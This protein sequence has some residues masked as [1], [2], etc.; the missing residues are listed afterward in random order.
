MKKFALLLFALLP[1]AAISQTIGFHENFELPS[2]ADS[3]TSSGAPN[4]WAITTKLSHGG[5]RSDSCRVSTGDTSYL[6]CAPFS[7]IG[8]S[9]VILRFSHICKAEI[10]DAGEI[11][12]SA[13]GGAWTKLTSIQYINPGNSQFVNSGNKFN[14]NTYPL[15]WAPANQTAIPTNTWWKNEQFDIS[16]LAG[17]SNNVRVRFVL[18]DGNNNGNNYNYGW[19]IDDISV[20]MSFSELNPPTITYINPL[21]LNIVYNIGPFNIPAIVSD[22]SGISVA[23]MFYKVNNGP[24]DSVTMTTI[25]S[26]TMQ[27]TIPA[28]LEGDSVHYYIVAYDASPA[29]NSARNPVSGYRSFL[30]TKGVSLPF[31]DNFDSPTTLFYDT[32]FTAGTQWQLGTPSYGT[33]A[34]AHSSPNAWDINLSTAYTDNAEAYLYSPIFDFSTVVNATMSFWI[35]YNTESYCDGMRIDYTIDG[36][37]WL[38]LGSV[39]DTN[40]T[41]WYDLSSISPS[42]KPA[43]SG[44]SSGWKK[45]TYLLS[46][47]NNVVGPV[48]FRFVF[49]SDGSST[50]DGFSLDDF[51]LVPPLDIDAIMLSS[52]TPDFSSCVAAGSYNPVIDF[53]NSGQLNIAPPFNLAYQLDGSAP[54][55]QAY[56]DTLHSGEADT[57][58]FTTPLVLPTGNHILKI[59]VAVPGDEFLAN[60]TLTFNF[61]SHGALALPYFNWL[62][63]AATLN[64]FCI[65]TGAYGRV[66]FNTIAASTGT[67]GVI[68]DANSSMGWETDIDT[69][70]TDTLYVWDPVVNPGQYAAMTLTVNSATYSHIVMKFDAKQIL[71]FDN[72]YTNFRVTVNGTQVTPHMSPNGASTQYITHEIDLTPFLPAPTLTIVFE[73]KTLATYDYGSPNGTATYIDNIQIYEPPAQEAAAFALPS[74]SSG[75]G[76]GVETVSIK[77]RNSGSDT[78]NGNLAAVYKVNGGAPITPETIITEILP[79]DTLLYTFTTTI[80]MSVTNIDS[81][82]NITAWVQLLSDPFAFNDTVYKTVESMFV[83]ANPVTTAVLVIPYATDTVL[84]ATSAGNLYW[85]DNPTTT[86]YLVMDSVFQTP[87]L[88]DTTTFYVEARNGAAGNDFY[89]GTGT[90]QNGTTGFPSPYGQYYNGTREQLLIPASELTAAG[91]GPGPIDGLAFDVVTPAGDPL[92]NLTL[93]LGTTNVTALSGWVSSG[94]QQVFTVASYT[95][96]T[97]WNQH[98]FSTPFVWD[99]VS[100]LVVESCFD[101]YPN[102][103]SSNAV[104]NQTTTTYAST[105]DYHSDNGGV[106]TGGT[107]YAYNQRPNIKFKAT[108]AGCP[109]GRVPVEV[110]VSGIPAHDA[111]VIAI[112][113][114]YTAINLGLE[115]VTIRVYNYGTD[116]ITELPVSYQING[117]PA[118]LDTIF[119]TI[120]SLDTATFTFTTPAN[121]STYNIYSFKSWTSLSGD[122]YA[123]NDTVYKTVENQMP[124][125]CPSNA[126][127]TYDDDITNLTFAG[128]NNN[129]PTPYTAT[130]TNYTSLSPAHVFKG[131]TYPISVG[132]GFSGTSGYS[133]YC[134]AYIDYNADGVFTEPGELVF[135]AAYT[136]ALTQILS[137]NVTIPLTAVSGMTTMRIIAQESASATTVSPCGTYSYGET[138]DYKVYISPILHKDAGIATIVSPGTSESEGATLPFTVSLKNNGLDTLTSVDI[139]WSVNAS[140]LQTYTWNGSLISGATTDVTLGTFVELTAMNNLIAYTTLAGDSNS[141]NDTARINSFGLPPVV[142]YSDDFENATSTWTISAGSLWQ[143]GTP[144]STVI[145]AA[146]SPTQCW[147]TRLTGNYL[148]SREDYLYPPQFNFSNIT[149]AVL[150]FWQWFEAEPNDGG[151]LQYSLNGGTTW[152]TLGMKDDPSGVNWYNTFSNGKYFWNGFYGGWKESIY[153]LSTFNNVSN[154]KFRYYFVTNTT[155]AYNGWAIDD[156]EIRVPKIA[157]DAGVVDVTEPLASMPGG[158]VSPKVIIKNFGTDTLLTIPVAFVITGGGMIIENWYGSL[159]PDSTTTYNFSQTF[160]MP[161]TSTKFCSF[162]G[163]PAD[164]YHFNDSSCLMIYNNTGIEDY[165]ATGFA[166]GQNIPNPAGLS[167]SI[168]FFIPEAGEVKLT[169]TSV[170]GQILLEKQQSFA[171]GNHQIQVDIQNLSPGLYYYTLNYRGAKLTRKMLI[172]R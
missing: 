46:A 102:G 45:S 4:A 166:L 23:K 158:I 92:I 57:I 54:V 162:T 117:N 137:G 17:N 1:L 165:L 105:I 138:E 114:P 115:L 67:G 113:T 139:H 14:S 25:I 148:N 81:T 41:N 141:F 163:M 20:L 21:Y 147:K 157:H 82:F 33:T 108:A 51:S 86:S 87:V 61:T 93:K 30:A 130:Y 135:G 121:L 111:G 43:W 107:P 127:S 133:G 10:L 123:I 134:K 73:S 13:N 22:P 120:H 149:G 96:V 172:E 74:P 16:A 101:N 98:L 171:G 156:F 89:V 6:T 106:C 88:Y 5:L 49:E 80:D 100:N 39:G 97:G 12:V 35:N 129:S 131:G 124:V 15:D 132:I 144:T 168:P 167:T 31:A 151:N 85:F 116:S 68:L 154:V 145:N 140:P 84:H 52:I 161:S 62:D 58:T 65:T 95:T 59:F 104:M 19:F 71:Y 91:I 28:V 32:T 76:L 77:F 50:Y 110:Q 56:T 164:T 150:K 64:D 143:H 169:F 18:R 170:L 118:V 152:I 79:G 47:L 44:T 48:Q 122:N 119:A 11:E 109:S 2:L 128:I 90:I 153:D 66:N 60:D 75:C 3:V 78:I 34:T 38:T 142:F 7:T 42:S 24:L 36:T 146:H 37:N 27:G 99:G 55:V 103:Y 9:F 69:I 53:A 40:A 26:D 112:D 159:P 136:T 126:T 94:M 63:S 125:Y 155:L 29:T 160:I 8:N 70:P 72:L 83:P